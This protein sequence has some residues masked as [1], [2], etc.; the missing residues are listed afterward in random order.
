VSLISAQPSL[1]FGAFSVSTRVLRH[2]ATSSPSAF[3][4]RPLALV[5]NALDPAH[6]AGAVPAAGAIRGMMIHLLHHAL[7][8]WLGSCGKL[9]GTSIYFEETCCEDPGV[10]LNLWQIFAAVSAAVP[11]REA[12]VRGLRRSSYAQ[13]A[14]RSARLARILTAHGL[15][16]RT[17]RGELDDWE[18]GQDTVALY[19]LNGHEYLEG[20]LGGYS[21]RTVP[22][23]VNYRYVADEL[24]HVLDDADTAAVVYHARYAPTLAGVLPRLKRSPLLLL[25]VADESGAAL[26]PGALDYEAALAAADPGSLP[27]PTHEPDDVHLLYTGGTT[28]MPKGAIWAHTDLW[29]SVLCPDDLHGADAGTLASAAV[30]SDERLMVIA[31]LMHGAGYV[32]AL[33]ALLGGGTVCFP[34]RVDHLDPVSIWAAVE[35]ERANSTALVGEAMARPLLAELVTAPERGATLRNLANAGAPL[36]QESIESLTQ[37]I[38]GLV[39]RD[40]VGSSEAGAALVRIDPPQGSAQQGPLFQPSPGAAIL[41]EDR[42]R[43]VEPGSPETGWLVKSGHVPLGYLG[44]REKTQATFVRVGGGRWVVVGDRAKYTPEGLIQLLGRDA[45]VINSGGE[46][47]YAE[48]V[49]SA[50]LRHPALADAVVVGRPSARWGQ[51][52]VAVVA[53]KDGAEATDAELRAVAGE[54]VARYKLPQEIVRVEAVRRSASGKVNLGWAREQA[55]QAA[56]AAE[57]AETEA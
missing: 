5:L 48:E 54:R 46:K 19:L 1:F 28:G 10:E 23:N 30:A 7:L 31:P 24:V 37:L 21:A 2:S 57:A 39:I 42:A 9:S 43:V 50:L 12:V 18:V 3:R 32:P 45:T 56:A 25:Q 40:Q 44:D 6:P 11:D 26:L 34:E 55:V 51:E 14:D 33:R 49:E 36:S 4:P 52:V 53:L 22:Y 35:R 15:G 27:V 13:L 20:S 16:V 38:P 47:I 41:D 8:V 29:H 17:A